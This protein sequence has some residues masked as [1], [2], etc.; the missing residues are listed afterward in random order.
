MRYLALA[1]SY[2]ETIASGG[3][4]EPATEAALRRLVASGRQLLL[5]SRRPLAE[6]QDSLPKHLFAWIV[7]EYGGV[8]HRP[9]RRGVELLAEPLPGGV[10]EALRRRWVRPLVV[11]Q[12][13]V[14]A[15]AADEAEVRAAV[16]EAGA[17]L[18]VVDD[19]QVALAL[20][21]GVDKGSGLAAALQRL[22]LSH[23][24]VVGVGDAASDRSFLERCECAVAVANAPPELAE[25]CDLVTGRPAGEGVAE[26]I[27]RLLADDLADAEPRLRRHRLRLGHADGGELTVAPYGASLLLAGPSGTGKSKLAAGLLERLTAREYQF[28]VLD[29]EGDHED[30]E[31][32]VHLG[33]RHEPPD[34][35]E[36]MAALARP[37]RPVVANLLARRLEDLPLVLQ[38]LLRRLQE[39]RTRT[40]RPHWLLLDEAHHFLPLPDE[41]RSFVLP[42]WIDGLA[43][44]TVNPEHVSPTALSLADVVVTFGDAAASALQ[45]YCEAIGEAAPADA[46]S[47]LEEGEALAFDRGGVTGTGERLVRFRIEPGRTERRPHLRR[48]AESELDERKSFWFRGEHG[49]LRLRA[50][51]LSMFVQLAEGVDDDTWRHHLARGDYSAWLR[52]GIRDAELAERVAEVEAEPDQPAE[53][54]RRRV[55]AAIRERYLEEP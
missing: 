31:G 51:T 42:R 49:R 5:L 55:L 6:L 48:W 10:V 4:I 50:Q 24:N 21:P 40:G 7:A 25:R 44:A 2:D 28:L 29:P 33:D 16:G 3:R 41:P 1:C 54:S 46:P 8:L 37:G 52:D 32:A 11:G 20:P 39:L 19:G 23:H 47:T 26:L 12:V 9:G 15:A 30:L 53:Q 17:K 14:A 45:R 13:S 27:D 34:A 18:T 35:D 36:I 22:E 43:M 38:E